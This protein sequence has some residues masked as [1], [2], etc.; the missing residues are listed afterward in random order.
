MFIRFHGA[1][2]EADEYVDRGPVCIRLEKISVFYDHTIMC[3]DS[4]KIRVMETAN[5]II[6]AFNNIG[7]EEEP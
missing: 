4:V 1:T 5:D 6:A 7:R 2:K 3:D